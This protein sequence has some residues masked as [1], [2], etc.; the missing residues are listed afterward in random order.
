MVGNKKRIVIGTLFR[1]VTIGKTAL[2]LGVFLIFG[3]KRSQVA[4]IEL[5]TKGCFYVIYQAMVEVE[6]T[7]II[8]FFS[9]RTIT[10]THIF[11]GYDALEKNSSTSS[12]TSLFD[13]MERPVKSGFSF[14]FRKIL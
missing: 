14:N 2:R 13:K 10:L 5:Y 12:F 6:T 7:M 11:Q 4:L 1:L 3:M 8:V 9:V